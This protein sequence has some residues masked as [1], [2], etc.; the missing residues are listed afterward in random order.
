[1][2]NVTIRPATEA[3]LASISA[4]HYAALARYHE[5]Y[6]AFFTAHPRDIVPLSINRAFQRPD[7][8]FLVAEDEETGRLVGFAR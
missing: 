8:W 6:A 1:M 5:F 3:D 7:A 2:T 4:I